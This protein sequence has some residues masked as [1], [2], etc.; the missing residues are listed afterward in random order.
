MKNEEIIGVIILAIA[1]GAVAGFVTILF[2]Q[3]VAL[4]L[5]SGSWCSTYNTYNTTD[6]WL[7]T[8]ILIV[9]AV[10]FAGYYI[11][12]RVVKISADLK[13]HNH[14]PAVEEPKFSLN[15]LSHIDYLAEHEGTGCE[16]CSRVRDKIV[17]IVEI[18][19]QSGAKK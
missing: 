2:P 10:A 4:P 3:P 17:K 7:G 8:A 5:D 9:A 1:V 12:V 16:T 14:N 6:P 15:E 19:E 11:G 18:R 13:N